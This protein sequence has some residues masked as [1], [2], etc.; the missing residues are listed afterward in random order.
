M[1]SEIN[2][3]AA[4]MQ[5]FAAALVLWVAVPDAHAELPSPTAKPFV[6]EL[7]QQYRGDGQAI[8][9]SYKRMAQVQNLRDTFPGLKSLR[10]EGASFVAASRG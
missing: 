7:R 3:P 9:W 10:F 6:V 1:F 5:A 8:P 2:L 4:L